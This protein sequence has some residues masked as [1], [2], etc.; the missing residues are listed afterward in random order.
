[1]QSLHL[2]NSSLQQAGHQC[3]QVGWAGP[4][5]VGASLITGATRPV[6]VVVATAKI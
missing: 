6:L 3:T 2:C 4:P 1:M 5:G